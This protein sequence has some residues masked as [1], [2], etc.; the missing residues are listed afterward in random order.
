[1]TCCIVPRCSREDDREAI[2]V[3]RM[4]AGASAAW[5]VSQDP[6]VSIRMRMTMPSLEAVLEKSGVEMKIRNCDGNESTGVTFVRCDH[7]VRQNFFFCI[8]VEHLT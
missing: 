5:S 6:N 7:G 1:M 4:I 3:L 8:T 2:E